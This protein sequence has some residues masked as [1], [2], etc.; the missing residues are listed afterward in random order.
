[1]TYGFD[2]VNEGWIPCV[3]PDGRVRELGL[4]PTLANAPSIRELHDPSPLVT[5]SLHRL[6]LAVLHRNFG[7][8]DLDA[9]IELWEAGR[10][11]A[12]RLE[13]YFDRWQDRFDLLHP[14]RPFYQTAGLPHQPVSIA[15]L[16]PE[17]ACANNPTLFDHTMDGSPPAVDLPAAARLVV[18]CQAADLGGLVSR[19][20]GEPPSAPAAPLATGAV[21][22]YQ[23]SNLFETL[24]LNLI[25]YN[26]SEPWEADLSADRPSWEQESPPS[27]LRTVPGYLDYLTW[28][29]R[30]ILLVPESLDG[31]T[32]VRRAVLTAGRR[33]PDTMPV[34]DPQFAL[35]KNPRKK[36]RAKDPAWLALRFRPDR[37]LWRDSTALLAAS[38]D[39]NVPPRARRWLG[40][41]VAQ[42]F[43]D[44][45]ARYRLV[46]AGLGSERAKVHFWR[47]ERMPLP[48]AY[49]ADADLVELLRGSLK[50]AERIG[51]LLQRAL[52]TATVPGTRPDSPGE[53]APIAAGL[54]RYWSLLEIPYWHLMEDLPVE[55]AHAQAVW[56]RTLRQAALEAFDRALEGLQQGRLLK[57]VTVARTWLERVLAASMRPYREVAN[58]TG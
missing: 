24:M 37:A 55:A 4:L 35:L 49:L 38:S 50:L 21:V 54:L 39:Y 58:E 8:P 41:L 12:S 11:D 17:L 5:A 10:W 3:M 53:Q 36:L 7:P 23:G 52:E 18:A 9:W 30:R 25:V 28:Q 31:R 20:P 26:S 48:L 56:A 43:L 1:V 32:V 15:K 6:L 33:L 16:A 19:L 51:W 44:R 46:V 14:E 34:M 13:A 45:S 57:E 2:L 47:Q 22:L 29:S 27:E 42:G 40:E